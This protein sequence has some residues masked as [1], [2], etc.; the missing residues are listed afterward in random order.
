MLSPFSW[1]V[2]VV[3]NKAIDRIRSRQRVARM[4]E[5]AWPNF[6]IEQKR[7]LLGQCNRLLCVDRNPLLL[8]SSGKLGGSRGDGGSDLGIDGAE[9][10]I[11]DPANTDGLTTACRYLAP[12]PEHEWGYH[13]SHQDL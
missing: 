9:G 13:R 4:V 11:R 6:P 1:A 5:R 7:L 3:R 12:R 2:L 8:Q 10:R